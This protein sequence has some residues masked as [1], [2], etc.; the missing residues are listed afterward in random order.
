M[1]YLCCSQLR[2]SLSWS[3]L[4]CQQP[5][6][7]SH[8]VPRAICHKTPLYSK[9]WNL[10]W[11]ENASLL[12]NQ[13]TYGFPKEL[14]FMSY[15]F[16]VKTC[17]FSYPCDFSPPPFPICLLPIIF[18]KC[19]SINLF[20]KKSLLTSF[21]LRNKKASQELHLVIWSWYNSVHWTCQIRSPAN[22]HLARIRDRRS[23]YYLVISI[24]R[25]ICTQTHILRC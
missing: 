6:S 9:V 3:D 17:G 12:L 20:S 7:L 11:N 8:L 15:S 16:V 19:Y 18:P 4:F 2:I 23:S 25:S 21:A 13:M 22:K 5:F 1:E 14:S 10:C 24:H